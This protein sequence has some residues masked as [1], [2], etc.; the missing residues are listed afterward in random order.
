MCHSCQSLA[1]AISLDV[2]KKLENSRGEKGWRVAVGGES[3]GGRSEVDLHV[4]MS[5]HLVQPHKANDLHVLLRQVLQVVLLLS[6]DRHR[7]L[8]I[9]QSRRSTV[10]DS[11]RQQQQ[12][13]VCIHFMAKKNGKS[14]GT[15]ALE[16]FL[17]NLVSKTQHSV[18]QKGH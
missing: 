16:L 6:R 18:K 2:W 11:T 9:L 5:G 8:A 17:K 14:S 13:G 7:L 12:T 4:R 15:R 10:M 1:Q 3:G